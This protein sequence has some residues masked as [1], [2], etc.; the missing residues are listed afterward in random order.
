MTS[1]NDF[2]FAAGLCSTEMNVA[3]AVEGSFRLG[4]ANFQHIFNFILNVSNNFDV[5]TNKT[6]IITVAGIETNVYKTKEGLDNATAP[7]FPN[8]S[9]VFLGKALESI[10]D[11][12]NG[13]DTRRDAATIVVVITSQKSDDDIAIPTINL[14]SSN[15][16][17]FAVAIGSELSLG[18]LKEIASD[19]DDH[20]LLTAMDTID[21]LK[22]VSTNLAKKICEGKYVI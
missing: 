10:K 13:N 7:R 2:A 5:S 11:L 3:F 21:L 19:P 4:D 1:L 14:K 17:V 20:H 15:M 8:S 9:H 22:N 12:L 18:Q 16:T 6:W